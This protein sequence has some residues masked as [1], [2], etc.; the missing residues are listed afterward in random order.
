MKDVESNVW[1]SQNR[2]LMEE[3][4]QGENGRAIPKAKVSRSCILRNARMTKTVIQRKAFGQKRR[5]RPRS[6]WFGS[7]QVHS[8]VSFINV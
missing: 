2:G 5:R 6:K 3:K 8:K 7:V 1:R 4:G